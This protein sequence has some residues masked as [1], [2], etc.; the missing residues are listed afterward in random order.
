M[1]QVGP[2]SLKSWTEGQQGK[3]DKARSF[4]TDKETWEDLHPDHFPDSEV[5]HWMEKDNTWTH[6]YAK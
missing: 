2:D 3:P 4:M 1:H 5:N 6:K